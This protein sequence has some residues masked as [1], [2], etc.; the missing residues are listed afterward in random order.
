[1]ATSAG[2]LHDPDCLDGVTTAGRLLGTEPR[3]NH[4]PPWR[5]WPE[6]SG[7]HNSGQLQFAVNLILFGLTHEGPVT[8][9][10]M[11]VI[12]GTEVPTPDENGPQRAEGDVLREGSRGYGFSL[13]AAR[14]IP[15]IPGWRGC[16]TRAA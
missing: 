7:L 6:H 15:Y 8:N 3:R 16:D 11:D 13:A 9:Q 2:H 4:S 1:M 14:S 12:H 10:V 5:V